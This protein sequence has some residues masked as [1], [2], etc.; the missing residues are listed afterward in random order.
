[1]LAPTVALW[2]EK[3]LRVHLSVYRG[4]WPGGQTERAGQESRE[5]V[6]ASPLGP[7]C[8]LRSP[9]PRLVLLGL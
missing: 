5:G 6:T 3:P 8:E 2:M 9:A 7:H 1:M 4:V